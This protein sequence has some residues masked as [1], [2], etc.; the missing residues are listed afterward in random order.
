MPKGEGEGFFQHQM[1]PDAEIAGVMSVLAGNAEDYTT[2]P[3]HLQIILN[4][5]NSFV[6]VIQ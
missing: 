1:R 5:H 3:Q 4:L 2:V 6:V